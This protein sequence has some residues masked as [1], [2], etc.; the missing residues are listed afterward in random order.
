[1]LKDAEEFVGHFRFCPQKCLQTLYPLEVR[2]DHAAGVAE[3]IRDHENFVPAVFENPVCL[4]CSRTVRCLGEDTA[5]DLTSVLSVN[6]SIDRGW[7]KDVARQSQ[8]F[9]WINVVVLS[10]GPQ[11]SLLKH[12]LLRGFHVNSL[13]IVDCCGM[14]ADPDDFDA[15]FVGERQSCHRADVAESLHYGCALFRIQLQHAHGPLDEVN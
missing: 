11:I 4:W 5:L 12:G 14:I 3:N 2:D 6:N 8:K 15:A 9:P 10:E 1:M 13:R 7:N